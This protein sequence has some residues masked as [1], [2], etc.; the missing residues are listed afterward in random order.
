MLFY[1]F[2]LLNNM[3]IIAPTTYLKQND[4]FHPAYAGMYQLADCLFA[5]LKGN[6]T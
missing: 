5:F 2:W 4:G 3:P 1:P 6:E